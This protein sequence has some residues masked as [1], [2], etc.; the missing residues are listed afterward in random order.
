MHHDENTPL[1]TEYPTTLCGS[2]RAAQGA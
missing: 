2:G 1:A